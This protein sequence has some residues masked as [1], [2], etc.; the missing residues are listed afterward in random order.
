MFHSERRKYFGRVQYKSYKKD[1]W[2]SQGGR[3]KKTTT[4]FSPSDS[5][6]VELPDKY[7]WNY[8]I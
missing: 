6:Y 7:Y 5:S 1:I 2:V 4:K 3:N 8:N